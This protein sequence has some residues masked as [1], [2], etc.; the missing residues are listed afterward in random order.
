MKRF[1]MLAGRAKSMD[2][3]EGSQEENEGN[4]VVMRTSTGGCRREQRESEKIVRQ[5]ESMYASTKSW[6]SVG[7]GGKDGGGGRQGEVCGRWR[8]HCA[9]LTWL[10]L[11]DDCPACGR[12]VARCVAGPNLDESLDR[13]LDSRRMREPLLPAA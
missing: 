11:I 9:H 8:R 1:W 3:S 13:H 4:I 2:G 12:S 5:A 7:R 10:D 6:I